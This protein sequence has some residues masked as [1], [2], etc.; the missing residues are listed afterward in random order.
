MP[1]LQQKTDAELLRGF[2]ERTDPAAFEALVQRHGTM[3]H[4]ASM[5]VVSNHHDAQ[6][7]TQAVFLALA[8]EA[9]KLARSPSVAGWLHTVARR[10]SLN[11]RQSRERRQRREQTAMN[12]SSDFTPDAT[13][14]S[15][16]RRE[17]DAAIGRLPDRYREPL[18]LFHL[19]GAPLKEVAERLELNPTTLRTRL[20]RAREM[21]RSALNRK[22]AGI[23]SV[24]A[25]SS[26]LSAET[27]AA[28]LAPGFLPTVLETATGEAATV[29][30]HVLELARHAAGIS[31]YSATSTLATLTILMKTNATLI[32]AAAIAILVGGTTTYLVNAGGDRDVMPDAGAVDPATGASPVGGPTKITALTAVD[33]L[34]QIGTE[35]EFEAL[36]ESVLLIADDAE[37]LTAIRERLGMD[38]TEEVY[39]EA[40]AAYGFQVDPEK[41]FW[42]LITRWTD[43]DP[44]AV[45]LWARRFPGELGDLLTRR[46]FA[47]WLSKDES[48][49]L[50]WAGEN[51]EPKQVEIARQFAAARASRPAP[52][53]PEA[54]TGRLRQMQQELVSLTGTDH[55]SRRRKAV[56]ER[57]INQAL[58]GWAE[59]DPQAAAEFALSLPAD[60][61][62][63]VTRARLLFETWGRRDP[64]AALERAEQLTEMDELAAALAALL[65]AWQLKYP[66]K[67]IAEATDL[68]RIPEA[69]YADLIY[70]IVRDRATDRPTAAMEFALGLDDHEMQRDAVGIVVESW[71]RKAPGDARDWV[72]GLPAGELRDTGLA[73]LSDRLARTDFTSA[74]RLVREIQD[75]QLKQ[76]TIDTMMTFSDALE[77]HLPEA[78]QLATDGLPQVDFMT[79]RRW[80]GK[81]TPE[82]IPTF[83]G[84]L[85]E[86]REAG[87]IKFNTHSNPE[88]EDPE[89]VEQY[90]K[91]A[92]EDGWEFILDGLGG[93]DD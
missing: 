26:L 56:L 5:R 25:L 93:A 47:S 91:K 85:E 90:N 6:D 59:Q 45:T 20:S 37:R 62:A 52:E 17:L 88:N 31:A 50:A 34:S 82:G 78:L 13:S 24:A 49:A 8:R 63:R 28:V 1:D 65:P 40:V 75:P 21:L 64:D 30:P 54:R 83:R 58:T 38:L 11:A 32:I 76:R 66:E 51:L 70:S 81:I 87:R 43:D 10:L 57:D 36:L 79:L 71:V 2:A 80:T 55:D 48:A 72:T 23:A 27:E 69:H 89:V 86:A 68:S 19:E 15:D 44:R 29:S 53:S 42:Q 35:S 46:M 74:D 4:A 60:A 73:K 9:G 84:W 3:V 14:R 61:H 67:T 77:R 39:R 33:P 12:D 41:L 7:V 92:A 18:V 22:G 16:F